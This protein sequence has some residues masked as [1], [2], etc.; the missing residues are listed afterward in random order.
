MPAALGAVVA[1]VHIFAQL[2][3]TPYSLSDRNRALAVRVF[4]ILVELVS[5]AKSTRAHLAI[6]QFS[7][8][9]A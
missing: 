4:R 3:F 8:G 2:A 5:T 9:F 7:S 6:L 1:L